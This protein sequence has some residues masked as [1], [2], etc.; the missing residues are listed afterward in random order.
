M[1][2]LNLSL[3]TLRSVR[4]LAHLGAPS[5]DLDATPTARYVSVGV[6]SYKETSRLKKDTG[7]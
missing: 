4:S 1:D 3:P 7:G 2:T 6:D 5:N